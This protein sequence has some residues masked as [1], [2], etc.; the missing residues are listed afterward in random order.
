MSKPQ[1]RRPYDA[2]R[3][4]QR[5][6]ESKE[7]VL[8]A[9]RRLFA[10]RGY[11]ETTLEAIASEAGIALP[12]LY[13]AFQS[14]RGV[15]AGVLNRLVSGQPG[16]P[17]VLETEGARAVLT[18]PDPR[19]ALSLLASDLS[20]IQERVGPIYEVMKSAARTEAEVAELFARAQHS[21][22]S[23]L[24]AVAARL[25]DLGAL[26]HGLTIERAARTIWAIASPEVRQMLAT[27]GGWSPERYED[28]LGDVLAAALLPDARSS[29][30]RKGDA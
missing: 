19:R 11:A 8:D 21:R 4:R 29:R 14:K 3:R 23:N 15:L 6:L 9:G 24:E 2:S 27:Y 26:R 30:K 5:A 10:E 16:G 25:A 1:K 18:E 7:R 12:S 13:A 17:P 20:A 28:W 22:Y